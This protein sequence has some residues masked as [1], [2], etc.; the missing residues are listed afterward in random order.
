MNFL[1]E[2]KNSFSKNLKDKIYNFIKEDLPEIF[3]ISWDEAETSTNESKSDIEYDLELIKKKIDLLEK[4][5]IK[6]TGDNLTT[7]DLV[8]NLERKCINNIGRI[9]EKI[10]D[11][12]ES[13]ESENLYLEIN[14][15]DVDDDEEQKET[16][17]YIV[18]A[19][20]RNK[21]GG[22]SP[23]MSWWTTDR[24]RA[25][26]FYC[27]IDLT[28]IHDGRQIEYC[29]SK[30]EIENKSGEIIESEYIDESDEE[31][32]NST[33]AEDGDE[34]EIQPL[35]YFEK[36]YTKINGEWVLKEKVVEEKEKNT[37]VKL[38]IISRLIGN[39]RDSL[40]FMGNDEEFEDEKEAIDNYNEVELI[41]PWE[42]KTKAGVQGKQLRAIQAVKN[43]DSYDY[44][45]D[46]STIYLEKY[47]SFDEDDDEEEEEEENE[48]KVKEEEEDEVEVEETMYEGVKYYLEGSLEDGK[49]YEY[50]EDGDIGDVVITLKDG[51][52]I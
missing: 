13:E 45:I 40:T 46:D 38:Y 44:D 48:V 36:T 33:S 12:E 32:N 2:L 4:N 30:S 7:M 24:D 14:E 26:N 43:N 3:K 8:E 35:E 39:S 29:I 18:R 9:W 10:G 52:K 31:E 25:M 5:S 19:L 50:L 17:L 49:L 41:E 11:C 6:N 15:K 42:S 37:S 51:N 1:S 20:K 22:Y 16:G 28:E 21:K 23:K 47:I 34:E 27:N